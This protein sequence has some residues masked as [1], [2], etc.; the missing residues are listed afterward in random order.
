[1]AIDTLSNVKLMLN[2]ATSDDD[3]LLARIQW[4]ADA[5]I[6][7]HCGRTFAGG[8][9][10]EYHASGGRALFLTNYPVAAVTSVKV[11]ASGA[12]GADTLRGTDTYI[13][14]AD[15]GVIASRCGPFGRSGGIPN[16]VQVVYTTAEDAVPPPISRAYAELI[17]LW[18][19]Q[20]KTTDHLNQ[21][22]LIAQGEDSVETTYADGSRGFRV[23]EAVLQ[24]LQLY[25][26]PSI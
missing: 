2:I 25:R 9:F 11:D 21:L 18:Y 14:L 3:A 23:P 26:A 17:G 13:V 15:R 8:T 19:R 16:A 4:A 5:F 24:M 12:F 7:G 10:T 20:A 22:N 1:M 6:E